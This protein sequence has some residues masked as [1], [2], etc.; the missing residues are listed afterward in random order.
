MKLGCLIVTTGDVIIAD[1]APQRVGGNN[2]S[3]RS[4]VWESILKTAWITCIE[5]DELRIILSTNGVFDLFL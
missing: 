4:H 1:A 3:V 5:D 2:K